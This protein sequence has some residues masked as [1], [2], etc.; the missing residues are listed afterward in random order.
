MFSLTTAIRGG[1]P[2]WRDCRRPRAIL[3]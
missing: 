3:S 1:G 2:F